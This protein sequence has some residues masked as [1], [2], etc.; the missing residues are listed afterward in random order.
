MRNMQIL[1]K[2]KWLE[3]KVHLFDFFG[4]V[5]VSC[6]SNWKELNLADSWVW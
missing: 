4:F 5:E 6:I 1:T 2:T 3:H